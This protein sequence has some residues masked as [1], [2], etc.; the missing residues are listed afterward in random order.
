MQSNEQTPSQSAVL[1]LRD[2]KAIVLEAYDF[3]DEKRLLL[4]AEL[5]KQLAEYEELIG[6][7]KKITS[8]AE[9]HLKSAV[10]RHG[11]HGLQVYPS[12]NAEETK[13]LSSQHQFMGVTLMQTSLDP[14]GLDKEKRCCNRSPEAEECREAFQELMILAG[15][16]AKKLSCF[17]LITAIEFPRR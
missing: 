11:L 8:I 4:A 9:K 14:Q 3:L 2:E 10:G 16:M 15:S 6:R 17:S 7:Y 12:S 1:Q 13:F 5:L